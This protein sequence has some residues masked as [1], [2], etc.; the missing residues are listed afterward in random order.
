MSNKAT[1]K[2]YLL[3]QLKNFDDDILENKYQGKVEEMTQ[4]E[5]DVL[6]EEEKNDGTIRFITDGTPGGGGGGS[7]VSVSHTGT[8]SSTSIRKQIITV[9][10]VAH[11]VD[12]SAYMEQTATLSTDATT[13]VVFTNSAITSDSVIEYGC[14]VYGIFPDDMVVDGTNNT[15]TITMPKMDSAVTVNVRIYLR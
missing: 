9:N 12:G 3:R 11:D 7:V 1:D 4:A 2:D 5:Y 10:N 13:S 8:A 15:C 14:S 6:S